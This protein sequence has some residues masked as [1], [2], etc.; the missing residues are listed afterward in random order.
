MAP[1]VRQLVKRGTAAFEAGEYS[2]AETLLLRVLDSNTAYANVYHMLGVIASFR[3]GR[4]GPWIS[5]GAL[6]R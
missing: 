1:D 4:K 2:E 3:G 5:S 6:W